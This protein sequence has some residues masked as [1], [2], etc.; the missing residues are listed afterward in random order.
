MEQTT[1]EWFIAHKHV[2]KDISATVMSL[3]HLSRVDTHTLILAI[4]VVNQL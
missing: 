4:V 3:L 1:T 2:L